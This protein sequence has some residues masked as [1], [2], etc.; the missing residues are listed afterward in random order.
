[1]TDDQVVEHVDVEQP[2]GRQCLGRQVEVVR[3]RRRIPGRVVV[4]EDQPARVE[5]DRVPEQLADPDERRRDVALVDRDDPQDNV[6]RVE[7]HDPQLLALEAAHLEDQPV[8]D[9]TRRP[10]RPARRRPVGHQP[11]P[12][13]ERGDQLGGLGRTDARQR[14]ELAVGRPGEP[15][16]AV[17]AGERVR[18]EVHRRSPTGAG[19]PQQRDQLRGRQAAGTPQ[20]QALARPLIG[21][22]LA[23]RPS[24]CHSI[25]PSGWRREGRRA[26]G[27]A[28]PGPYDGSPPIPS[29]IRVRERGEP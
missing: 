19:A 17:V 12:Q 3:R 8:G 13:L 20:R 27:R 10:D 23:D 25:E 28:S 18:G 5:A 29:A 16:Q 2:P 1:M 6:L 7:E 21:R 4:D 9:V 15:R 24:A 11:P 26:A 22:E 14:L